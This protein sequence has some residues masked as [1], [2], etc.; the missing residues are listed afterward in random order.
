[1][2]CAEEKLSQ[3]KPGGF[4]IM[5]RYRYEP[6]TGKAEHLP[7][8]TV[9]ELL[10]QGRGAELRGTLEPDIVIHRGEPNEVQAVRDFKFPCENTGKRIPW[11]EYPTGHVY[12]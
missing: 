8:E 3:L 10:R 1:M 12:A 2:Q 6:A 9:K 7:P 4:S 11:R 5:P